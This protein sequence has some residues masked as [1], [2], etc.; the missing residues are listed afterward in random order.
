MIADLRLFACPPDP[1]E[2]TFDLRTFLD[3]LTSDY[4]SLDAEYPLTVQIEWKM[5]NPPG[6]VHGDRQMLRM[7]FDALLQNAF[8]ASDDKKAQVKVSVGFIDTSAP[9]WQ[10]TVSD[11]GPGITPEMRDRIFFPYCSGRDA[12]RGLGFGLPRSWALM[13]K[14]G[15]SLRLEECGFVVTLPARRE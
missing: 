13:K 1:C 10:I 5:T 11:N 15:G 8:E 3:E 9:H 4:E 12:G 14:M 7:V 6:N 2:S